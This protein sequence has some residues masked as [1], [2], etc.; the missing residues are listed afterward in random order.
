MKILICRH[1]K[2]FIKNP[3]NIV[4]SFLSS[5]VILSLYFLFIRNFTI[6]AVSDYGFISQYNELFVDKLMTSG[7]L[8]VI[9]ATSVLSITFIFVKDYSS[10][11]L[12]DFMV[13][14]ISMLKIIYSYFFAAFI[15][16]TV[17]TLFIYIGISLFFFFVYHDISSCFTILF[18][19]LVLLF[20]NLLA[21]NIVLI[22]ALAI[23]SFTSFSMFETLYG[24]VIG[25]FTGV[26]IPIG[27][28]P[29]IIR[30]IFFYFPLCQTTSLLR[31]IQTRRVTNLILQDYP[32]TIHHIL[33]EIF[34]IHLTF[35]KEVISF[36]GQVL[37]LL[38]AF[39]LLQLLL[40][41]FFSFKFYKNKK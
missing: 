23:R 4:L 15:I 40:I 32:N 2:L 13:S 28:Y 37:F 26:Y 25:F 18:S 31:E 22:I 9:G 8:I 6:E 29:Q 36:S 24:V 1:L 38:I 39:F 30:D 41:Y 35:R 16:S 20:S 11:T 27:Y 34:G 10:G 7:L 19:I 3:M 21:S 14:P 33:Y 5:F 12:K 17:I